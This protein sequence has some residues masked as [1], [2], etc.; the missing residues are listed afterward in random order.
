MSIQQTA[1]HGLFLAGR[2]D[3]EAGGGEIGIDAIERLLASAT[4]DAD[5]SG[6]LRRTLENLKVFRY[7]SLAADVRLAG[8]AGYVDVALKGRKRLGIF[9]GP[10]DAIN[11]HHVPL[12]VLARTFAKGWSP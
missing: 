5:G 2:I 12:D 6:L 9:P 1:A 10:V 11:L 3:G 7:D 8:A 4:T